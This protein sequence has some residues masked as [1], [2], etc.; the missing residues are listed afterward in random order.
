MVE[1]RIFFNP[2]PLAL[3]KGCAYLLAFL[4]A[5][6]FIQA[7][8]KAYVFGVITYSCGCLCDYFEVAW[9][10]DKNKNIRKISAVLAILMIILVVVALGM[11]VA[12]DSNDSIKTFLTSNYIWVNFFLLIFWA[13][14]LGNGIWLIMKSIQE[15]DNKE[16]KEDNMKNISGFFVKP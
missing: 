11:A 16:T 1:D 9:R 8:E 7:D 3:G 10:K 12:Y 4:T 15:D 5:V 14:P 2:G 13:I 6:F